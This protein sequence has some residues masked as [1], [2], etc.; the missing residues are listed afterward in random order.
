MLSGH[1]KAKLLLSML[2]DRATSVLSLLSPGNAA[3]LTSTIEDSP[4]ASAAVLNGLVTEVMDRVR[5]IRSDATDGFG[6]STGDAG[7]ESSLEGLSDTGGDSGVLGFGGIGGDSFSLGDE[8]SDEEVEVLAGPRLRS[9]SD[10]AE[11][12]MKEKPQ[13]A[14]FLLERFEDTLR[15]EVM[16]H[17]SYEFRDQIQHLKVTKVPLSDSVFSKIYD[18][19]VIA[20]PES[21]IPAPSEDSSPFGASSA[22]DS[23]APLFSF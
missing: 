8:V 2:G 1:E 11:L 15:D 3:L 18:R 16:D 4:K 10:I 9:P 5:T 7:F 19:I 13:I 12:L 23:G 14:A 17:L 6:F 21:D 20:P 22:A